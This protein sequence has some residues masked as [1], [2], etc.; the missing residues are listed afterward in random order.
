MKSWTTQC[1]LDTVITE[2]TLNTN[3]VTESN[4]QYT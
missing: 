2:N 1:S 3:L 4:T